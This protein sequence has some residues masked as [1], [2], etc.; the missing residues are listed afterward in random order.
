MSIG[1]KILIKNKNTHK[2]LN[3]KILIT[4]HQVHLKY[5]ITDVH[6]LIKP[7]SNNF[8]SPKRWND[9]APMQMRSNN[10]NNFTFWINYTIILIKY[11]Y[12]LDNY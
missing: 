2:I 6:I 4:N 7:M 5:F 12:T 11:N 9:S 8:F 10:R 1:N 3:K